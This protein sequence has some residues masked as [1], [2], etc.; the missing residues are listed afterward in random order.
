M[1]GPPRAKQ[2]MRQNRTWPP[3]LQPSPGSSTWQLAPTNVQA[4][5]CPRLT[6]THL[7]FVKVLCLSGLHKH[8]TEHQHAPAGL[9]PLHTP[10]HLVR[11]RNS[12]QTEPLSQ[13]GGSI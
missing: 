5:A 2:Q 3:S 8:S 4:S 6:A 12:P 9:L 11:G 7:P 13:G 1:R 10:I